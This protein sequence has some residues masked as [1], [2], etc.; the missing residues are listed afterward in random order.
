[1]KPEAIYQDVYATMI[2]YNLRQLFINEAQLIIE[3]EVV[4]HLDNNIIIL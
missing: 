3:Q 2:T 4:I 1:M